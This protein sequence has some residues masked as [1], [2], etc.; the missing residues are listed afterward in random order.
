MIIVLNFN[1][2]ESIPLSKSTFFTDFQS[3]GDI[4]CTSIESFRSNSPARNILPPVFSLPIFPYTSPQTIRF[5]PVIHVA[6]SPCT[7]PAMT[8]LPPFTEIQASPSTEP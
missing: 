6:M 7:L 5:Q 3:L 8:I 1:P 2:L 4:F